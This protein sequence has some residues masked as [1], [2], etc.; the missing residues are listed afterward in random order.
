MKLSIVTV[1]LAALA[2]TAC[3][4]TGDEGSLAPRPNGTDRPSG[5]EQPSPPPPRK[6]VDGSQLA[7]SPVNLVVDPG[8]GL[9]GE[10]AGYGS[11]LALYEGSFSP[12]DVA[13][14]FDSRSPAGFG[15]NV[16]VVKAANAN[17]KR[18]DAI[19]LL[20]S[21][22]GGDGPFD[23]H[24]WVSKS[25]VKGNPVPVTIDAKGV[26]ASITDGTPDG[27]AFDL[28]PVSGAER[29]AG[30]RT[31][32]L[33][34]AS[35]AKPLPYG[36]F[37]VVRTGTG[38]GQFLVAAPEVT[39]RPLVDGLPARSL[40]AARPAVARAS[41]PIERAAT[42]KYKALPPRLVPAGATSKARGRL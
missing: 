34:R 3:G 5:V 22:L 17:D 19:V 4:E 42:A 2:A 36:G 35:V 11:F 14:T 10:Q 12:V 15:G 40:G 6:L 24:V 39:A 20:T 30:G 7:T 31:W 9:V 33:L 41:S 38:G 25:D 21:F 23:A 27:E 37:F 8:F 1:V 26:T 29:T 16:A 13:T 32:V 18:S 28:K